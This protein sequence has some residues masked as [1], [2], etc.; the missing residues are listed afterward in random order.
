MVRLWAMGDLVGARAA[1]AQ[2]KRMGKIALGIFV[3]LFVLY[4]VVVVV[5]ISVAANAAN[6]YS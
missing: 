3:G 1:S 6:S 2:A 4:V 5:L